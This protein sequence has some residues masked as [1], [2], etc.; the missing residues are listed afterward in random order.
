MSLLPRHLLVFLAAALRSPATVGAVAPSSSHLATRLAAVVPR[1]G[2]P[3][4]LELGPGTGA[5]TS[6]I[7]LRLCGRGRHLAVEIDAALA[8]YLRVEHPDVEVL[9]GDAAEVDRLLAEH[10]V[11]AVDVVVSAL[12][13]SLIGVGAQ[14]AIVMNAAQSLRPG[15]CF[16]TFVGLHT[17]AMSRARRFRALLDEV[18]DEVLPTRTIWRN[19]PPAVAYVC[20]RPYEIHGGAPE[21]SGAAS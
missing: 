5:V 14:R 6:A 17:L 2:N 11:P 1:V 7:A 19:L 21:R 16:A 3:V 9:V 18:F 10:Q 4:V 20:R 15:G 12:P 13:W 8:N